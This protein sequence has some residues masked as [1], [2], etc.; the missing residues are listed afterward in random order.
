MKISRS[1]KIKKTAA[2]V[3]CCGLC[4]STGLLG[5]IAVRKMPEINGKTAYSNGFV[6]IQ[7][8]GHDSVEFTDVDE[9]FFAPGFVLKKDAEND[10]FFKYNE[11]AQSWYMPGD[12][13]EGTI[14]ITNN[15]TVI[16]PVTLY[17]D[18]TGNMRNDVSD[19]VPKE[20]VD[21]YNANHVEGD[22][23]DYTPAQLKYLSDL[24]VSDKDKLLLEIWDTSDNSLVYSG[25]V[26]GESETDDTDPMNGKAN[27]ISLGMLYPDLRARYPDEDESFK[28]LYDDEPHSVTYRFRL[29][30][31][32]GLQSFLKG[33][34]KANFPANRATVDHGF[35][36]AVAMIDWV[37]V[38]P[39]ESW[40]PVQPPPDSSEPVSSEPVSSEPVS[41]EPA[42]TTPTTKAPPAPPS[43]GTG[44]AAFPYTMGAVFCGLSALV[45]FFIAFGNIDKKAKDLLEDE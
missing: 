37:F 28:S 29:T 25:S 41:S 6:Y 39:P 33:E 22:T 15:S 13:K 30:V 45:I 34:E 27:A 14:T 38:I 5:T 3:V 19:G 4:V 36:G 11:S 42:P 31:G 9:S 7:D 16:L 2:A 26:N 43:P 32:K 18:T 17:A 35:A 8:D 44:E 40:E 1:E 21:F 20:F 12:Y 10:G 24:M 23:T